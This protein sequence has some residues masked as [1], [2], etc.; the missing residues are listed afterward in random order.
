MR[1]HENPWGML[2]RVVFA[3]PFVLLLALIGI[4]C[5]WPALYDQWIQE[6]SVIENAQAVGLGA[7][8]FLSLALS[9]RSW[10]QHRK[11]DGLYFLGAGFVLLLCVFEEWSWLQRVFKYPTPALIKANNW[12]REMTV[13]NMD[14]IQ[15]SMPY[16][17][18]VVG[19]AGTLGWWLLDRLH[20]NDHHI[21]RKIFPSWYLSSYFLVLFFVYFTLSEMSSLL[22]RHGYQE[23]SLGKFLIWR[24]QEPAELVLALGILFHFVDQSIKFRAGQSAQPNAVAWTATP[25]R[26]KQ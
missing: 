9:R 21:Q 20:V 7:A 24:D 25:D 2:K 5:G 19:L 11:A 4:K 13:H 17:Y 22:V 10:K 16:A 15:P 12:Q 14:G 26:P 23:W 6:D 18:M 1:N 3:F 8:A